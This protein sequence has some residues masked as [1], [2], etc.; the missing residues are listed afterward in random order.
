MASFNRD[1]LKKRKKRMKG[2]QTK[3]QKTKS[4][5]S[6][7]TAM[8]P[9]LIT[10]ILLVP[11]A[12]YL[13]FRIY[14]FHLLPKLWRWM[15]IEILL[16][17]TGIFMILSLKRKKKGKV[18]MAIEII[19]CILMAVASV[20]L[21]Y[22]EKKVE[23]VFSTHIRVDVQDFHVYTLTADY[24]A[25]HPTLPL[26]SEVS[27]NLLDY[28]GK[29]FLYP[30]SNSKAQEQ[31]L[32]QLRADLND[33]LFLS[34]KSSLWETLNTFYSGSAECIFLSDVVVDMIEETDE[35]GNFTSD[36]I[37]LRTFRTEVE[38]EDD[39]SSK[40]SENAFTVFVAGNDTRSGV[41]SIYG[42]TDVDIL[43]SVNPETAQALIISI[44]RD[45]YLRNPAL[46]NGLDKLTHLGNNGLM[47]TIEGLNALYD[48]E[49]QHYAAVNFNT[50]QKIIDT[51]GGIDIY[52]P[53]DFQGIRHY[54]RKGYISLNGEEAL[55][56]VRERHTLAS[57]DFDRNEHQAIVLKAILQR[58]MN[59]EILEKAPD[60]IN[61]LSGSVATNIDPSSIMELASEQLVSRKK[62]NIV[63]YHLGGYGHR[64]ETV[65]MPG[66][67]L[68]VVDP[69]ES[70]T[71]FVHDEIMNVLTG[72][73]LEQKELPD[74]D[75][76]VWEYN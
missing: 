46:N 74:A 54:F 7:T 36:T 72:E 48:L 1:Y 70:Q 43:L 11:I 13:S 69:Y 12:L 26:S 23:R 45:T 21:P 58:M 44:P 51:L 14:T 47:N 64:A 20:T 29:T 63:Y 4:Q 75:K 17:F 15:L 41:L 2:Q 30:Q 62:W 68:Y 24:R 61:S 73:I 67:S 66:W 53:Y 42:R 49:V 5:K 8:S 19:L 6:R 34:S 22:I 50:F 56:Y 35:Y 28:A 52:N 37:L 76:T 59:R 57:G 39:L 31:A 10:G 16:P 38:I 25:K 65:S 27:E 55:D 40:I 18:L 32:T 33:D 9:V 3:I 71:K 60:L